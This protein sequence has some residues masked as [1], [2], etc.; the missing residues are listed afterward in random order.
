MIGSIAV[1]AILLALSAMLSSSETVLFGL[2]RH[3]LYRC[4]RSDQPLRRLAAEMMKRPRRVLLTILIG[5]TTVNV[6]IF[7]NSYVISGQMAHSSPLLASLWGI[8]VVVTVIVVGEVLAKS[9]AMNVRYSAAPLV[10]PAIR[11]LEVLFLPLRILLDVAVV[12]PLSRLVVGQPTTA[13]AHVT[14]DEMKALIAASLDQ[15]VIAAAEKDMLQEIVSLAST[16]VRSIMVP[17]VDMV[18]TAVCGD[19][20]AVIERLRS[21]G[22]T[23]IPVYDG[24]IDDVIGIVHIKDLHLQP[25]RSPAEL[26]RAVRFVPELMTVDLLL[27]HF[28]S[29]GTQLSI[30]V[31]EYGGVAG[32][33][34]IEDVVEQIVGEITESGESVQPVEQL[35]ERT[36][37]I[38]GDLGTEA[39]RA[40][41]GIGFKL[42]KAATI[43][44]LIAA[45]LGRLPRVGDAVVFGNVHMIVEDMGLKRVRRVRVELHDEGST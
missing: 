35:S 6:L 17:R 41:F 37:R 40:M 24:D 38:A 25:D 7:A 33:V 26:V 22:L 27:A 11:V 23:K 21:G 2:T 34:S 9:V 18:T 16:R 10:A 32:V 44:G 13:E 20:Q 15:G 30:V 3:E 45:R 36:Y 12:M 43:G 14:A 1:L 19:R 42:P 8:I 28:R 4:Q 5:N 29:T 31:D 39:W